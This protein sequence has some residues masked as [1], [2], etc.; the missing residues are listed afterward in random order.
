MYETLFL[1]VLRHFK[2]IRFER[3]NFMVLKIN[4]IM[5]VDENRILDKKIIHSDEEKHFHGS[6]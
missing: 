4:M 2:M 6:R 3:Y 1:G 5:I